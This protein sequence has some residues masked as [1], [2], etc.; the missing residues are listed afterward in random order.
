MP[1]KN[2]D[3]TSRKAGPA[4]KN[5]A[6]GRNQSDDRN[7]AAKKK[8][9]VQGK[10]AASKSQPNPIRILVVGGMGT[11]KSSFVAA[12]TGPSCNVEIGHGPDSCTSG[13]KE[14]PTKYSVGQNQIVL[15]DTPGFNDPQTP[16]A[17]ILKKIASVVGG[18]SGILYFYRCTDTRFDGDLRVNFEIIKTMC[19][20]EFYSRVTICSTFWNTVTGNSSQEKLY[21]HR[22]RAENF[23]D[24]PRVF[25]QVMKGGAEYRE[26]WKDEKDPCSDILQH[27]LSQ[28]KPPNMAIINQLK[29][30]GKLDNTE[31]GRKINTEGDSSPEVPS[32]GA[33]ARFFRW[34]GN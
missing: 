13:C 19:G 18:I 24:D 30:N 26:F 15:I 25:G 17:E 32:S 1:K 14:Y 10:P 23:L 27:F 33:V 3:T 31:A 6:V 5:Q 12:A 2:K 16:N 9:H 21:Q 8:Q 11:G 34:L 29:K 20:P 28:R 7:Q 22:T 4:G